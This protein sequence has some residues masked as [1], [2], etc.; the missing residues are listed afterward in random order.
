[1]EKETVFQEEVRDEILIEG[2]NCSSKRKARNISFLIDGA[3]YFKAFVRAAEQ[4][5]STIY[6]AGWDIDSR[7]SLLRRDSTEIESSRF[8]RFLDR[9][10]AGKPDLRAYILLWDFSSLFMLD[11]EFMPIF[12]LGWQTHSRIHFMLDDRHPLGASHHEKIVV[13]DDS[14][15]FVGGM[16]FGKGRWDTSK[17]IVNDPRRMEPDGSIHN[18][19]HDVQILLDG[20]VAQALGNVFRQRWYR[21]SGILLVSPLPHDDYD[22]PA[23]NAPDLEDVTVAIARTDPGYVEPPPVHEIE[24]LYRDA[25][26]SANKF[27]YIENQYLTS[28][29]VIHALADRLTDP[30]GPEIVLILPH[31]SA[32]WLEEGTMDALRAL[33]LKRLV[34]A[35]AFGRLAAYYPVLPGMET[36]DMVVHSKVMVIDND[37]VRIG[38]SNLSNRSMGLDTECDVALE[39]SGED[40]IREKI[41]GLRN[42]LL[43]EHLGSSPEIVEADLARSQSLVKTIEHLRNSGRT[44]KR[45]SPQV[46]EWIEAIASTLNV[47]DPEKPVT[48]EKM[49]DDFVPEDLKISHGPTLWKLAA[50]ILVLA[51]LSVLWKWGPL[52]E[53]ITA[54]SLAI[55]GGGLR[56]ND[57]APLL[58]TLA[59]VAGTLVMVPITLLITATALIFEPWSSCFYAIIGCLGAATVSY[60]IGRLV[61]R[62]TIRRIAG[63]RVN[64]ISK[65]L[66]QQNSLTIAAIR[67]LPVAP[68]PIVNLVMGASRVKFVNYVIGTFLGLLPGIVIISLFAGSLKSV[69]ENPSLK[70]FIVVLAIAA[71]SAATIFLVRKR[72]RRGPLSSTKRHGAA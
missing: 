9:V 55:W 58:V 14:I 39:S 15:A 48:V 33:A 8:G 20:D 36:G 64:K 22:W 27:I 4:A 12:K 54:D 61:G 6:I 71:V 26:A 16:D 50:I 30:D 18:P 53:L 65:R 38:S 45:L 66:A 56:Q 57:A 13:I 25:I 42:R 3:S 72:W 68:F 23:E 43:A 34:Q 49:I 51:G 63:N 28:D 29:S 10:V 69:W 5:K 7:I 1:M 67:L 70:S 41:A 19:F 47:V 37:L 62:D 59:Y 40:R 17:H 60:G 21:A 11:R 44:L 24:H 35:D 32:G 2:R 46:P 31:K 52:R